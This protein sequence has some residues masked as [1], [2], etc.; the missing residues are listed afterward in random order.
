MTVYLLVEYVRNLCDFDDFNAPPLDCTE[1]SC[2]SS[3]EKA[4]EE[5]M[6][7]VDEVKEYFDGDEFP[8]A[9]IG[10]DECRFSYS[11]DGTEYDY[12][13]IEKTVID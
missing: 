5:F 7:R 2:F 13:V 8:E 4:K 10:D 11:D 3:F 1:I 12:A 9:T 6:A